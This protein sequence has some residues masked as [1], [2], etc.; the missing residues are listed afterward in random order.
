M[1]V[2]ALPGAGPE[3]SGARR[4]SWVNADVVTPVIFFVAALLLWE[5]LVVVFKPPVFVLPAP[6]QIGQ[7]LFGNLANLVGYGFNTFLEALTGFVIGCGL[8]LL[9]AMLV[10][11]SKLLSELLVPLAVASNSVPI[12]AMAPI[13][14]VWFGIGPA[15]KV[16]IVAIMCFFPMLVS[17]VRGLTAAAPDA[18][19]LMRSYAASDWQIFTKLRL[20][21]A[22]PFIF[23]A[24]KIN[25]AVAMIGA[26]VA[27]FF[28]GAVNYLGVYIKTEAGILRT[29]NAWA[30]I[31]IAC[32][33]GL[34]FY[35]AVVLIE[36]AVMPWRRQ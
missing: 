35:L 9:T 5:L 10:A 12:V 4:K 16:A 20:P 14:I 7:S 22:L 19:A 31:V 36:R 3:Q 13:A 15:S 21:T 25:T 33:F 1:S 29:T 32:L 27:E 17:A 18:V 30:A 2:D 34:G 26:I 24:C 11:R 28:G 6:H 23:N 8:G